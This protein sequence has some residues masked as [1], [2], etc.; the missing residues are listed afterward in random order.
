MKELTSVVQVIN[1]ILLQL[2]E[3]YFSCFKKLW[4]KKKKSYGDDPIMQ[5]QIAAYIWKE[6]QVL[7]RLFLI[8]HPHGK[9]EKELYFLFLNFYFILENSWLAMVC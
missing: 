6:A 1:K 4:W 2:F 5:F 9:I 7:R 8:S 3:A